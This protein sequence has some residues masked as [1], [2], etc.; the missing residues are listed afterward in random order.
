MDSLPFYIFLFIHLVSLVVGFGSVLV[1]D[2]FG[3]LWM[4]GRMKLSFITRVADVTQKLIWLGYGGMIASG[5]GLIIL[6]GY[7]DN[8]TKIKIFFVAMVGING[9]FLHLIKKAFENMGDDE[10]VPNLLKFRMG[11]ATF[12]SQLGWWGAILIGF[13]HRHYQ[14]YFEWPANPWCYIAAIASGIIVIALLGELVLRKHH[15]S[16][17][18]S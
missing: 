5:L 9:I 1:T 11:L 15:K 17:A 7:V 4:R 14:H 3:L 8:L 10:Q 6:K 18:Q 2:F 12:V 13:V 16:D